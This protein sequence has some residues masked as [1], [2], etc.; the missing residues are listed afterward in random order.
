MLFRSRLAL[1]NL[2]K[3]ILVGYSA[4]M[5]IPD[6][7]R[8]AKIREK[9]A[10]KAG[11]EVLLMADMAHVAGLIAAGVHPNPL[12]FGFD[13]MT[14]TTHK[15]LRGP[16]GGLILTKGNVASPLKKPEKTLANLPILIDRAVF[17]GT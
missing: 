8:V 5:K 1:E 2:P 7:A 12:D 16:R 9:V 15:T 11:H 6:F 17:P 10:E 4:F 3:L 14:T 13:L